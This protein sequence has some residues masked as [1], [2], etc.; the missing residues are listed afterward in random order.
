MTG[1]VAGGIFAVLCKFDSETAKRRFVLAGHVPFDNEPGV[2]AEGFSVLN[3]E[4]VEKSGRGLF[5]SDRC[6]LTTDEHR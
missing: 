3:G 5:H 1:V 6:E 2:Q 4:G